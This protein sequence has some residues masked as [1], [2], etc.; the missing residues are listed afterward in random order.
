M[1]A[2]NTAQGARDFIYSLHS[3]ERSCL[4]KELHRFESIA[5]AQGEGPGPVPC[6]PHSA[7]CALH[8]APRVLRPAPSIP[9]RPGTRLPGPGCGWGR[10]W[11]T[12]PRDV[13]GA[14]LLPPDLPADTVDLLRPQSFAAFCG[15]HS[16]THVACHAH[17]L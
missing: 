1:E 3:S 17:L 7:P 10:G 6:T 11:G 2:L 4:L 9:P 8:F 15:G 12:D 16:A 5:I 14:R 13:G